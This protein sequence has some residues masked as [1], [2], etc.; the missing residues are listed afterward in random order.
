[1][2]RHCPDVHRLLAEQLPQPVFEFVCRLVGKRDGHDLPRRNVQ[3]F[4]QMG[5][6]M[7]KHAGFAGA[8]TR[9]N[10]QGAFR[11]QHRFTLGAVQGIKIDGHAIRPNTTNRTGLWPVRHLRSS[12]AC[13][14]TAPNSATPPYPQDYYGLFEWEEPSR[15]KQYA[16]SINPCLTPLPGQAKTPE[17][18]LTKS[19][20]APVKQRAGF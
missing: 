13:Y 12:S 17:R 14:S 20:H 2:E 15:R 10:Q 1:M 11:A 3:I 9:Q 19:G 18:A 7:S 6:A 8:S 5:N 4:H 16:K